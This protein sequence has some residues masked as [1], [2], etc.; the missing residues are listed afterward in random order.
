[1]ARNPILPPRYFGLGLVITLALHVVVPVITI[2]PFP[3]ALIGVIPIVSGAG[4]NIWADQIFKKQKTTLN[5]FETPS[6]IVREG[7]FA[8]SRHP[9]YLGMVAILLGTSLLC[10]SLSSLLGPIVFWLIVRLRFIPAEERSMIETFGDEYRRYSKK[11][12]SW[13]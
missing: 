5:P 12:W 4:I 9:M 11:V 6:V 2:I 8:C 10:G 13:V 1:M 7:P 3:L